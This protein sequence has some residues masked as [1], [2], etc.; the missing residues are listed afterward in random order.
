MRAR[1]RAQEDDGSAKEGREGKSSSVSS[2][3]WPEI[4][5]YVVRLLCVFCPGP[6][7]AIPRREERVGA[8]LEGTVGVGEVVQGPGRSHHHG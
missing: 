6:R 1:A 7:G 4:N 2:C 3:L 5:V 8:L